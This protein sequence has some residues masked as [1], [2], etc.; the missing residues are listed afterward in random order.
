MRFFG[1]IRCTE[2]DYYVVEAT[3][4]G[5]QAGEGGNESG[6]ENAEEEKKEEMEA[7]GSGVNK[8]TYF[9]TNNPF[10]PWKRLPDLAPSHIEAA[11]K[12]KV[13]FSGNL[14]RD[15]IC[16]PFFFG[17]EKHLL[18]AQ[19][20]RIAHSTMLVPRSQYKLNEENDREIDEVVPDEETKV[21]PIPSTRQAANPATWG[22][23]N[24]NILLNCRTQHADPVEPAEWE[25]PG[26]WDPETA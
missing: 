16:N 25:G 19:L 14:E 23:F 2:A 17:K 22:H 18:R 15:I 12:V 11:R 6:A 26:E 8:Y 24:S 1:K 3:A 7:P 13:L 20:A 9:V 21:D 5:E 10:S 4:E